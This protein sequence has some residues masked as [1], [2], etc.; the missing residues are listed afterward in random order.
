MSQNL[1]AK[2]KK[3]KMAELILSFLSWILKKKVKTQWNSGEFSPI[4]SNKRH[5]VDGYFPELGLGIEIFGHGGHCCIYPTCKKFYEPEEIHPI[6]NMKNIH[7][8]DFK[9]IIYLSHFFP[10]KISVVYI[11]QFEK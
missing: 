7:K 9:Q 4:L 2:S 10:G 11:C 1:A 8:R 6:L 3:N 5:R